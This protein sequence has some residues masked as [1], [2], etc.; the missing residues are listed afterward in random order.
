M[1]QAH[2]SQLPACALIL[3]A[4]FIGLAIHL[5]G[6]EYTPWAM[7]LITL[8]ILSAGIALCFSPRATDGTG[9]ARWIVTTLA[10]SLAAQ[11]ALL[12]FQWPLGV[13][14]AAWYQDLP[15]RITFLRYFALASTL[16]IIGAFNLPLVRYLWFPGVLVIHLLLGLWVV[17]TSPLPKI[18]VWHFQQDAARTL[19]DGG[20]PYDAKQADFPDIYHSML[21]GH[22]A[23]YGAGLV[24]NDRLTFG[25][26]YP[27]LSL[28]CATA[29]LWLSERITGVGE[30]RYAQA[31]ALT[32]AGL[33]IG[34]CRAG[35]VPKLSAALLLFTPTICFILGR[36]WTE[37]F[38]LMF[39]GALMFVACRGW[40]WLAPVAF[41]LL[42]ASKQYL[43][44][45]IP[46]SFLLVSG[47]DPRSRNS[48]V[49]WAVL[50]LIAGTSAAAVTL[51]LALKDPEAFWFSTVTVQKLAPFRWDALSY[52]VW[53]GL[54]F[55][56]KYTAW[57][58][59]ALAAI[60]PALALGAWKATKTPSGFA[61]AIA[62]IFL[63]FIA[64]NK[65]AFCNYYFFVIGC[66]CCAVA[67][68]GPAPGDALTL[69]KA[70]EPLLRYPRSA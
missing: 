13:D 38:V 49:R 19:L 21:P 33:L 69:Q 30:T 44:L 6:G 5:Q 32:L 67:A 25:F 46:L 20:N 45:A 2:H 36:G 14:Q 28:Y 64:F 26:P 3:C 39:L 9:P 41:G 54:N 42:L 53:L 11:F 58:W 7:G 43:V 52:L 47:F 59:L 50:I 10:L 35:V 17:R 1:L 57:V 70:R 55:D 62:L 31:A 16:L 66:F 4:F 51:P 63:V 24:Q 22:Q 29:G 65:Q 8:A 18:D 37:P 12:D 15:T 48:W 68:A 61:A 34:Y 60:L 40:R 23:V 56:S 27:P